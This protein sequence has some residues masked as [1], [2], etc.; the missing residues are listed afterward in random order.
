MVWLL[1]WVE[2]WRERGDKRRGG[3]NS[4]RWTR[5]NN[6]FFYVNNWWYNPQTP[7]RLPGCKRLREI[8][9]SASTKSSLLQRSVS[10]IILPGNEV[11]KWFRCCK[12]ATVV[13]VDPD[14]DEE[15]VAGCEILING[16]LINEIWVRDEDPNR[17]TGNS[18]VAQMYS[19][20]GFES[21]RERKKDANAAGW[22][23]HLLGHQ[24]QVDDDDTTTMNESTTSVG[25]KRPRGSEE[26]QW[27]CS[28]SSE[29]TDQ[30]KQRHIDIDEDQK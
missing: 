29:P 6:I 19:I 2:S 5:Q 25:K 20:I 7:A 28:S 14:S 17:D 21:A 11:P 26:E 8:S 12:D 9:R 18:Y 16:K 1:G 4:D 24:V 30:P 22:G 23:V 27:L 3:R 10:E 13:E 15:R